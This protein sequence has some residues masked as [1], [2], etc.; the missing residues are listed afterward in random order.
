MNVLHR[1]VET[2]T[3]SGRS[4]F[5]QIIRVTMSRSIHHTLKSIFFGK[6]KNAINKMVEDEDAELLEYY[7][8]HRYRQRVRDMRQLRK[9]A[10]HIG[11]DF[12]E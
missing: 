8:K 4:S 5:Q 10:D 6:S 11:E 1:P 7:K 3:Q 12:P 9:F 2:A